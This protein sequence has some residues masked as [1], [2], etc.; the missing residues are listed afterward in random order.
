[1]ICKYSEKKAPRNG[2]ALIFRNVS[3][4]LEL[5]TNPEIMRASLHCCAILQC[6]TEISLL[7]EFQTYTP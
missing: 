3:C 6:I 7:D 4:K 2:D 5:H 1:M